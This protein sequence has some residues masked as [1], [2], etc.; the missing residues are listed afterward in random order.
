MPKFKTPKFK[1]PKISAPKDL[2]KSLMKNKKMLAVVAIAIIIF[3]VAGTSLSS[4]PYLIVGPEGVR[5]LNYGVQFGVNGQVKLASQ[6]TAL[7]QNYKWVD[8]GASSM[9]IGHN[10][11]AG[12]PFGG[13]FWNGADW[14]YANDNGKVRSEIQ[15]PVIQGDPVGVDAQTIE[16]YQYTKTGIKQIVCQ[17]KPVDFV[18][19]I[20]A[21]N[22]AGVY[23]WK[24]TS[25]WYALDSVAW[26]NAFVSNPQNNISNSSSNGAH[27]SSSQ[28]RGA[29]PIIAWIG[30]YQ[31]DVWKDSSGV[32]HVG[33]PDD[34][35]Q[36]RMQLNPSMQGRYID[37]YSGAGSTYNLALSQSQSQSNSNK[38]PQN[39]ASPSALPDSRMATTTYFKITMSEFGAYVQNQGLGG[40]ATSYK[41]W[42]PAVYFRVR[43]VYA[44]YGE[45]VY[46]WNEKNAGNMG[47][48]NS[49]WTARTTTT[50]TYTDPFTGAW[51]GLMNYFTDPLNRFW[52][53]L[54]LIIVILGV[55][56]LVLFWFLGMPKG[57]KGGT[58]ISFP[59]KMKLTQN[60]MLWRC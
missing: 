39:M 10:K 55:C 49:T 59:S 19:Q 16:Y 51:Q 20:D 2:S 4:V 6:L 48:T 47:Y 37:L 56:A 13:Y 5:A 8:N 38:N 52:W 23:T 31:D 36:S 29:Y 26:Q 17:I 46:Q 22:G 53:G 44:I 32:Q 15:H 41:E 60:M 25:I 40:S 28:Y 54:F 27:F 1:A 21:E 57:S 58:N 50:N 14:W 33:Y 24:D 35:A 30:E 42:Y 7:P 45:Y 43:V 11:L 3:G 9:I 34:R 18:I 12:E